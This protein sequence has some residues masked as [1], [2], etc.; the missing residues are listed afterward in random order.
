M[1]QKEDSKTRDMLQS[2]GAR[3][4]A[5]FKERMRASGM[6]Q[7][8]LWIRQADFDRGAQAFAQGLK[9]V[10]ADA[11]PVSYMLG[12]ATQYSKRKEAQA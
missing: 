3:R 1:K 8:T 5:A 11:D 6:V 4:Q 12:Y 7:R 2:P 10:P 9:G